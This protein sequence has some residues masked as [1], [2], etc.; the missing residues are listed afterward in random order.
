LTISW[1][2]CSFAE[3]TIIGIFIIYGKSTFVWQRVGCA[4]QY[5]ARPALLL[6]SSVGAESYIIII[7]NFNTD[8][9][10]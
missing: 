1:S 9:G 8:E 2:F 5:Q 4:T 6:S 7:I 3:K 10:M